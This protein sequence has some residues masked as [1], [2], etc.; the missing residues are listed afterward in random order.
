MPSF[1]VPFPGRLFLWRKL[2]YS[3][4]AKEEIWNIHAGRGKSY[5]TGLRQ[6]LGRGKNGKVD[7]TIYLEEG[8]MH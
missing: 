4:L 3:Q 1:K 2:G 5:Y 8:K 7:G 6:C